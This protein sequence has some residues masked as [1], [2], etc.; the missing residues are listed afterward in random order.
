MEKSQPTTEAKTPETGHGTPFN[1]MVP[2]Q[3]VIFVV[4]VL[5]CICSFGF[6]FPDVMNM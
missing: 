2:S 5:L 4:K 3:K 1:L 6:A